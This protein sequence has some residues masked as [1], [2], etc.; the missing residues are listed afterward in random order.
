MR[1]RIST[2]ACS[3]VLALL[4]P[5]SS[6]LSA[7]DKQFELAQPQ[8]GTV[9]RVICEGRDQKKATKALRAAQL[10]ISELN[11][12]LSDYDARSELSRLGASSPHK[13]PVSVSKELFEV[14]TRS[15]DLSL[16]TK[17]AFDITVGPLTKLWRRARRQE[18]LPD[19][20]RLNMAR[21][22]VGYDH[23]LLNK[24]K[25]TVQ[26][27]AP[28]MRL[29]VGG[30]GKGYAAD[31]ALAVLRKMGFSKAMVEIGGDM[32]LGDAPAG[33]AGWRVAIAPLKPK[34]PPSQI[35]RLKNCGVA[36]SGD[37]WQYVEIGGKRYSHILNPSSGLGLTRRSSATVIAR[38]GCS[39][40]ALASAVSVMGPMSAV[41]WTNE[42]EGVETF[43]V[44]ETAGA[45][46]TAQ[47]AN[48]SRL[49]EKPPT[50]R[51]Q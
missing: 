18:K 6:R 33:T 39:A 30:I 8:M 26:L 51:S 29:D 2:L 20:Q 50:A 42:Q 13:R 34:A 47:S 5:L 46:K 3:L 12:V 48:F 41:A 32:A 31:E 40:D 23:I 37:V 21:R 7:E 4:L 9:A 11:K 17:G 19:P 25:Q 1:T 27:D 35:M 44:Y 15:R 45:V 49:L 43:M 10:R 22:S 28:G 24:S 16:R 36:T 14:L 38:D